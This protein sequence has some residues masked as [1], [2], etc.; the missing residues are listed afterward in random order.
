MSDS[1][2]SCHY[3]V[4]DCI[5]IEH[6]QCIAQLDEAS[7]KHQSISTKIEATLAEYHRLKEFYEKSEAKAAR[8]REALEK[9]S[10][11]GLR[12]VSDSPETELV[13]SEHYEQ[14]WLDCVELA[15]FALS[16]EPEGGKHE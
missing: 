4:N 3:L 8:Y 1:C 9:I 7:R 13:S 11:M 5:C 12:G 14:A 2:S 16:D 10:R 6:R 15:K